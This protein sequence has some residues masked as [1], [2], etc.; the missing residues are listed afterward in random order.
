[1]FFLSIIFL[2]TS[3][4]WIKMTKEKKLFKI[5][6]II[7]FIL[8]FYS[9]FVLRTYAGLNFF[10][11]IILISI[12]TDIGGYIF[13]K[14]FKGPKLTK[15]SPNKTYSGVFGSLIMPVF[16]GLFIFNICN[17]LLDSVPLN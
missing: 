17:F 5:L 3:F 4:E 7:F 16:A 8:S 15:I 14:F 2:I 1:M 11:F 12:F 13:G 10:L 6:G 9:A